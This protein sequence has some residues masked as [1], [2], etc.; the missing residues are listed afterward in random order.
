MSTIKSGSTKGQRE[1]GEG[2]KRKEIE[3]GQIDLKAHEVD[4]E[5][6]RINRRCLLDPPNGEKSKVLARGWARLKF[7]FF[8][9]LRHYMRR[10][11]RF[12]LNIVIITINH[13]SKI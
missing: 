9:S 11:N 2:G 3:G 1:R 4:L 12:P 8:L 5:L 13:A 7:F 6:V 10:R